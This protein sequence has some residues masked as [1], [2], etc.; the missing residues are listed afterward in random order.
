[1]WWSLFHKSLTDN[2]RSCTISSNGLEPFENLVRFTPYR[3]FHFC[4]V[5]NADCKMRLMSPCWTLV[6]NALSFY[7]ETQ[8]ETCKVEMKRKERGWRKK[9]KPVQLDVHETGTHDRVAVAIE[10]Y[11]LSMGRVKLIPLYGMLTCTYIRTIGFISALPITLP[12]SFSLSLSLSFSLYPHLFSRVAYL[13]R[14]CY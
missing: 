8:M 4:G 7:I 12:L 1:M 6:L 9:K 13:R 3:Q 2:I 10:K 5:I 11:I 14:S